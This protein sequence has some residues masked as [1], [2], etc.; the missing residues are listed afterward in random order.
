MKI[1]AKRLKDADIRITEE[2]HGALLETPIGL[3]GIDGE[4]FDE[5]QF[6]NYDLDFTNQESY[7]DGCEI[8][9]S[10][11][12]NGNLVIESAPIEEICDYLEERFE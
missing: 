7:T 10:L 3:T 12:E 11:Y 5:L 4:S 9:F 8:F 1:D 2:V 6:G